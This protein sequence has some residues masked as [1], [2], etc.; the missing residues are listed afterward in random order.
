[1]ANQRVSGFFSPD[2]GGRS[3]SVCVTEKGH[4]RR[5]NRIRVAS[6]EDVSGFEDRQS[7]TFVIE[8]DSVVRDLQAAAPKLHGLEPGQP[9]DGSL[10]V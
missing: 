10:H 6:S 9:G 5:G 3:Y 8:G 2:A 1:M 4:G 7:V